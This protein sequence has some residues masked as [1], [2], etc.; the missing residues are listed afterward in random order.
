MYQGTMLAPIALFAIG[1]TLTYVWRV[2]ALNDS[3]EN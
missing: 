1:L 3:L 2:W